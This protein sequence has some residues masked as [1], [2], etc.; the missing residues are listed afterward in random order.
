[1]HATCRAI[2]L[3]YTLSSNMPVR[4]GV[5][6]VSEDALQAANQPMS[7]EPLSHLLQ[8]WH[9]GGPPKRRPS[10]VFRVQQMPYL[11]RLA[12]QI[13]PAAKSATASR[14]MCDAFLER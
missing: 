13:T 7:G 14:G 12:W 5:L 2:Q 9:P 3:M 10:H 4:F 8:G 6:L 1:M 11:R